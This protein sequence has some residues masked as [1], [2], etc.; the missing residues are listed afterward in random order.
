MAAKHEG[1]ITVKMQYG[2]QT[3]HQKTAEGTVFLHILECHLSF[4][5]IFRIYGHIMIWPK[6]IKC[7]RKI[8][9]VEIFRRALMLL[10]DFLYYG[11]G[12][13]RLDFLAG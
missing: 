8:Q 11:I 2:M 10:V 9:V 6:Y 5:E 1:H 4:A 7:I 3:P 13:H 12:Y